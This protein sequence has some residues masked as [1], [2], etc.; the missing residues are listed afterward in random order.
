MANSFSRCLSWMK[1]NVLWL[2]CV[3]SMTSH[4]YASL[5]SGPLKTEV[6]SETHTHPSEITSRRNGTTPSHFK[7]HNHTA[8]QHKTT[9][10]FISGIQLDEKEEME[11]GRKRASGRNNITMYTEIWCSSYIMFQQYMPLH[12]G[13]RLFL[14]T[15]IPSNCLN[16]IRGSQNIIFFPTKS[17]FYL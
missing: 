2:L 7:Y 9:P 3:M 4:N 14:W 11:T 13:L 12:R 15:E 17:A 8:K 5:Y 1:A 10:G 6:L 16:I